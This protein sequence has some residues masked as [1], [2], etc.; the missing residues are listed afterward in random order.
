MNDP[1]QLAGIHAFRVRAAIEN[2]EL[3][4]W[5]LAELQAAVHALGGLGDVARIGPQKLPLYLTL[6]LIERLSQ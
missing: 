2:G 4:E 1:L 3:Q 5:H 6:L